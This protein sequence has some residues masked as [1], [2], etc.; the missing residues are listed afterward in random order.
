LVTDRVHVLVSLFERFSALFFQNLHL[1][2]SPLRSSE[3]Y[4]H[5]TRVSSRGGHEG[6]GRSG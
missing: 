6:Q 3:I 2:R 5:Y 4:I 1:F